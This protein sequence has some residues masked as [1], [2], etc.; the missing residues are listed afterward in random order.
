MEN[1]IHLRYGA[2]RL[3]VP[4]GT[5]ITVLHIGEE[6]TAV[7][8]G[9]ITNRTRCLFFPSGQKGRR[10]IFSNTH[11]QRLPSSKTPS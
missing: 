2:T 6:Q 9:T 3:G 4:D 11:R 5:P 7:A 8:A 1:E 10:L